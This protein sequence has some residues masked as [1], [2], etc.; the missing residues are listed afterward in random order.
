M[1]ESACA[2]LAL[3]KERKLPM[4]HIDYSRDPK[5]GDGPLVLAPLLRNVIEVYLL[6]AAHDRVPLL[7][8]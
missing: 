1:A 7:I 4:R 6:D 5:I 2:L 8:L 3:D